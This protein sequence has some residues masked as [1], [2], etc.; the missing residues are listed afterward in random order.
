MAAALQTFG[1]PSSVQLG[2]PDEI[3]TEPWD[4]QRKSQTPPFAGLGLEQARRRAFAHRR[5]INA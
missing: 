2:P 4:H 5:A 3:V 1:Q